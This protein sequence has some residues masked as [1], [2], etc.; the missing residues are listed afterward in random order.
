MSTTVNRPVNEK[1]KEI[2]VNNK[3]QL[4]GIY[5]A[6]ANGKV[7]SN[8][9]IDVALNSFLASKPIANPSNRLSEEGR[10][11]VNDVRDVIEAAKLL[12][13]SKNEGNLFQDFVW[14]T[15]HI[16]GA[17]ASTP[18]APLD[19]D[20]AKQHGNEALDGLRTLGTLVI[21]NGQFRKLL[22][23]AVILLRDIAGDAAQKA[24]TKVN[25]SEDALAQIDRP[26]D[27]NT[28]HETPDLSRENIRNQ[29]KDTYNKNKPL[30]KEDLNRAAGDASQ[31]AHPSGE[32]DPAAVGN[33]AARDQQYGTSS[34]VNAQGGLR[35]GIDSLNQSAHE[36]SDIP[37]K[38]EET[39][40][41]YKARTNNYLKNKMPEDRRE[42]TIWRLKKMVVEIQ[43]HQDYQRAIDTL[44]RLAEEYSGHSRNVAQQS[45]GAVKG[46]HSDNQLKMAEAD[47]KVRNSQA[48]L[49]TMVTC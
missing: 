13:L 44:L 34:G 10:V 29:V 45:T 24:A 30:N 38:A 5:S 3:L 23:D 43:G 12:V 49:M 39:A 19:K 36:N 33:A 25:P 16:S 15:Q 8:K 6:F 14:Q 7:P 22:N 27:D 47:L 18:N 1:A 26:A 20:T 31:T 28:W 46:A 42:Q 2:D 32:R 21:S 48:L 17:N 9:Q 11:L 40:R 37:Q 41:N 35:A 4:Y